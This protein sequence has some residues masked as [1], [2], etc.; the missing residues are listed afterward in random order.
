VTGDPSRVDL[1]PSAEHRVLA[2]VLHVGTRVSIVLLVLGFLVY[3]AGV[4]PARVPIEHLPRYWGLRAAEY[5][6]L[7]ELPRGWGWT[8]LVAY[9]DFANYVGIASLGG[10]TILCYLAVLPI[11]VRQRDTAYVIIVLV[12]LVVLLLA[13]SGLVSVGH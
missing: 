11:L 13:A 3:V 10:L 7:A 1:E 4:L 9:G 5:L 12:Q 8:R 6:R 2:D